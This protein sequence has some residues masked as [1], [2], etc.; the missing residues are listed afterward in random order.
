MAV[1]AD[2]GPGFQLRFEVVA[3]GLGLGAEGV[4]D[5]VDAGGVG[6]GSGAVSLSAWIGT[7]SKEHVQLWSRV[8]STYRE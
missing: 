8:R 1:D 6:V 7:I 5:E 2:G 4:A 3:D